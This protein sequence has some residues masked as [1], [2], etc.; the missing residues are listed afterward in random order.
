MKTT[1]AAGL[2]AVSAGLWADEGASRRCTPL[3][4]N[5]AC[6]YP[7]EAQRDFVAGPVRFTAHVR[8]D[9][10]VA[11]VDVTRVPE[12]RRGFEE[13]V[14]ACVSEWRFEPF[15]GQGESCQYE[16]TVRYRLAPAEEKAIR[17]LLESFASGWN[18]RDETAMAVALGP[19]LLKQFHEERA[20]AEWRIEFEPEL[21]QVHFD[22]GHVTVKQPFRR[23]GSSSQ[24][25]SPLG[26][27]S[28]LHAYASKDKEGWK[29]TGWHP[30]AGPR[31]R[32]LRVLGVAE[33]E[34]LKDAV[35][36]FPD[37]S[38]RT[39]LILE[40]TVSERGSVTAVK[41]LRG[42]PKF[43][44]AATSAVRKW[45]YAPTMRGGRP[46]P[47]L[48]T[49]TF[50]LMPGRK[51]TVD[52]NFSL[53]QEAV[54]DAGR[55]PEGSRITPEQAADYYGQ[56]VVVQGQVTQIGA[57]EDGK[58][59]FLNFG[60]RYPDHVFNA[61]ILSSQSFPEARSWEGKTIEVRGKIQF[62]KGTGKP[63]IILERQEQVTIDPSTTL[64]RS[65]APGPVSV[66]GGLGTGQVMDYDSPPRPIK[67]TRP[68]YPQE[69]FLEKIEGTVVVE[70]LIDSKGRV[71]R[72]RVIKSVPLLDDA[73]L[74]TVYQWV[75]QPAVKGGRPVPTIA[76]APINF[77]IYEGKKPPRA[78]E[79]RKQQSVLSAQ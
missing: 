32:D 15:A 17:D 14:R 24:G 34:R 10:Q 63:E 41:I 37:A 9:G 58:T 47:I 25:E 31:V 52:E 65:G 46:V 33:P 51:L 44:K 60:G 21:E 55:P 62:Y 29:L 61:V 23:L 73:A 66:G 76:H 26:P 53:A 35:P 56:D 16:G 57:S 54:G 42:H 11:S 45:E 39:I 36:D 74:Q 49:V 67:I 22:Q 69:A 79:Q 2:L 3:G 40:C 8:P 70:I 68:Q 43:D 19:E 64:Q 38:E 71:T 28:L 78:R 18:S 30:L 75:F 27:E 77:E 5:R 6:A 48:V 4:G 7:A 13:S 20:A 72:A 12:K 50:D 59:L 1:L